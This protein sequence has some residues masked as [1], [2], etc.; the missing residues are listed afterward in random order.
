MFQTDPTLA[1]VQIKLT[2]L[3]YRYLS[4]KSDLTYSKSRFS[5]DS[6]EAEESSPRSS[7]AVENSSVMNLSEFGLEHRLSP[8]EKTRLLINLV[9]DVHDCVD[10][11]MNRSLLVQT[12]NSIITG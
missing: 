12:D 10:I 11:M 8:D 6:D 1:E 5:S 7:P 3:I 4:T 9:D 2:Q